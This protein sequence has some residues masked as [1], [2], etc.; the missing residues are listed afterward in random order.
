MS[1]RGRQRNE[2]A[3]R[4]FDHDGIRTRRQSRVRGGNDVEIDDHFRGPGRELR[5]DRAARTRKG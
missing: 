5:R 4:A 3:A 1:A 2:R